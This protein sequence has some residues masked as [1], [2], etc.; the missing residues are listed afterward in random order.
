[1][2][3]MIIFSIIILII[4][5]LPTLIA[6]G[7]KGQAGVFVINFFLG[8]TFLGWIVALTWAVSSEKKDE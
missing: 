3:E 8:W 6:K 7:K 4:Y 5:F 2:I 1:M